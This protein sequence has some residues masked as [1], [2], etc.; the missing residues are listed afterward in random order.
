MRKL[1]IFYTFLAVIY[2]LSSNISYAEQ[3][4]I[5]LANDK[6][7]VSLAVLTNSSPITIYNDES[8]GKSKSQEYQEQ[9]LNSTPSQNTNKD[10][11][12]NSR[13]DIDNYQDDERVDNNDYINDLSA[14]L[15]RKTRNNTPPQTS[16]RTLNTTSNNTLS[17]QD[18]NNNTNDD[19]ASDNTNGNIEIEEESIT[20]I[21]DI[22]QNVSVE[23]LNEDIT[24]VVH[25]VDNE[26]AESNIYAFLSTL[27]SIK[28]VNFEYNSEAILDKVKDAIKVFG[29]Y[30]PK[31][32]FSFMRK[33]NAE[34]HVY[35][36]VGKPMWIRNVELVIL[37]EAL[38][39][40]FFMLALRDNKLKPY[41]IFKHD[42]YESLK[43][44]IMSRA[45]Q[46]GYFDAHFSE[47]RVFASID[48]NYA[49]IRLVFN[50]GKGYYYED[51]KFLGD[52]RYKKI[53][54]PLVNIK[55]HD[56]FNMDRL[57]KLS[58][59]LYS[60]NYFSEAE[61][62]PHIEDTHD[63]LVPVTVNLTRKKFNNVQL[64]LGYAT[65]DGI[66]GKVSWV[67]PLINDFGHA[68][69]MQIEASHIKQ[70]F[71][72][73]YTIP[74]KN[75]LL[76]Y[77]YL[78]GS[79]T[80]DDL[81]DTDSVI[82]SA[83]AHFILKDIGMWNR[84]YAFIAQYEDYTQ[85]PQ[86]GNDLIIGPSITFNSLTMFPRQDPSRASNYNLKVFLSPKSLGSDKSFFQIHGYAKWI[87]SP[88]QNS[89]F[90]ARFEQGVN[91]GDD[92]ENAPPSFRFFTGGDSSIRGF[93]YKVIA[94]TDGNGALLG[95]KY[96]SVGSLEIQ[97]PVMEKL[98]SNWFFDAGSAANKYN[99][100]SLYYSVGTGIRY[101]SP[102][103]LIKFD[104]G[105]GISQ[106]S[107]PFHF[108]FGIGPDI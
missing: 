25:G 38:T 62:V 74:L 18:S 26:Q 32:E 56:R 14:N 50:S 85:G 51:V 41:T 69:S 2:A 84:D 106:T 29:Y 75:P 98:R 94:Q 82:T 66:R 100:D 64:G 15:A 96:L 99:R 10:L 95:G 108:H 67:M 42:N 104:V 78:L 12:E 16:Q 80:Y 35:V 21:E 40:P 19:I 88:T 46:M 6:T 45:L 81:N 71:L 105:F 34:L 28:R 59:D 57:S 87:T 1:H 13:I 11:T 39:D 8:T 4:S 86:S 97:L 103:G 30:H 3:N 52:V 65:D 91:L 90:V 55:K 58:S 7:D 17:L 63:S 107:I 37:G 79:Q 5:V 44:R 20:P 102:V 9:E 48:E 89:R 49:D 83:Q 54:E 73:R 22:N 36:Q 53:I 60:T 101:V 23:V 72:F 27:P 76:N 47:S 61:V 24:Y 93:G 68:I 77:M 31:I 43:S 92:A 70:E 33:T